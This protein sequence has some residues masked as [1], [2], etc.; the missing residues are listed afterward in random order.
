MNNRNLLEPSL[1]RSL[2]NLDP[3]A[4]AKNCG[5]MQRLGSKL[6]PSSWCQAL[7]AA[8]A[9]PTASLRT[10]GFY[11]GMLL[12]T[13]VSKQA[14]HKRARRKGAAFLEALLAAALRSKCRASSETFSCLRFK[15]ILLQDATSM[16]L[17]LRMRD[18][19]KGPGN[20]YAKSSSL[21][22]QAVFDLLGGVFASLKIGA[23]VD[24]DMAAAKETVAL[25]GPGD[26][27]CW[28]LGYFNIAA[29][30]DIL[31]KGADILCRAKNGV[32]MK[33]PR[34]R[35]RIDL[36]ELLQSAGNF[37]GDVLVGDKHELAM[38]MVAF[39]LPKKVADERRRKA[40]AT[41]KRKGSNLAKR[42]LKLLDW[43][44]YLTSCSKGKL[45]AAK[46][47]ELYCQRWGIEILFKAF[48][49]HMRLAE[50]PPQSSLEM[51][52]CLVYAALLRI[53]L[54]H[55]TILPWARAACGATRVSLLKLSSLIEALAA[56]PPGFEL[57]QETLE[58]NL[59]KHC[60][61][62]KRKRKNL[63]QRLES[64]G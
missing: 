9:I 23:Y 21:K 49:S 17:P 1:C 13:T 59:I 58:A 44:V 54:C 40:K 38:R 47:K 60:Q 55:A 63:F 4:I 35:E 29:F 56:M 45:P 36:L 32:V 10:V 3:V 39:R 30:R 24:T 15:R 28:D 14:L 46:A 26:L 57:D 37:D 6:D 50:I 52:Q 33:D 34:T 7:I 2:E 19:Y 27:L 61:Y 41:A 53:V 20:A 31:E 64:L 25:V 16:N 42:D 22:V 51:V 8:S 43:Q 11:A 12:E 62:D 18:T 5:W 48:K